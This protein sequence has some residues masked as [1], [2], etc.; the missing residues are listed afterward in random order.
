MND[1]KSIGL[2]VEDV[3]DEVDARPAHLLKQIPRMR[4]P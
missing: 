4:Q 3:Q 1:G 2:D